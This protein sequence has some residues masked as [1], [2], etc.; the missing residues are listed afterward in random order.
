MSI[1]PREFPDGSPDNSDRADWAANALR[2][3]CEETGLDLEIEMRE[4][5]SDLVCNLGHYCD[6]RKID[7]LAIA[8]GAIAVWDAEKREDENGEANAL[9]REKKVIISLIEPQTN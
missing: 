2:F 7:F 5:V 1:N 8:A 6:G 4:A 3:F 9:Y